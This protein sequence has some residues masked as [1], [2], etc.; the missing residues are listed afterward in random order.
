MK[1]LGATEKGF[2]LECTDDELCNLMGFSSEALVPEAYRPVES[3]SKAMKSF[4]AAKGSQ[5]G[6]SKKVDWVGLNL[7][8]SQI[9]QSARKLAE[10]WDKNYSL[11]QA[12]DNLKSFAASLEMIMGTYKPLKIEDK[13]P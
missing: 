9:Y 2:L 3:H 6:I 11:L 10:G 7:P 1:V 4:K 13:K 5:Y 12:A 8:V